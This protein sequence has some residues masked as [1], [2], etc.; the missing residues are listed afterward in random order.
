MRPTILAS[1][2]RQLPMPRAL[3]RVG[4][5][6]GVLVSLSAS[7]DDAPATLDDRLAKG[8]I[9]MEFLKVEGVTLPELHTQLVFDAPPEQVFAIIDD[10][11]HYATIMPRVST[12]A[13]VSRTGENSVCTWVVDLPF[14]M[15]DVSTE[16]AAT[17]RRS[18]GQWTREFKQ[19][20]GGFKR[21]EGHW[22]LTPFRGDPA[23]T[24]IDYRLLVSMDTSMPDA[25]VRPA[26]RDGVS[27][28]ME[29]IRKKLAER[30]SR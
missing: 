20:S 30:G 21:N 23:R 16:V 29:N 12:S 14:P 9:V 22:T 19:T 1:L 17:S 28:L 3:A 10:C 24:R 25:F 13:E 2:L 15:K 8:E 6:L 26:Q 27:G 11:A 4:T 5:A 18:P 7:A